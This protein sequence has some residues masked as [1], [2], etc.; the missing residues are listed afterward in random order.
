VINDQQLNWNV[1]GSLIGNEDNHR[2]LIALLDQVAKDDR[3]KKLTEKCD[4]SSSEL[5]KYAQD[6][7]Q[8]RL[9]L[10]KAKANAIFLSEEERMAKKLINAYKSRRDRVSRIIVI[11]IHD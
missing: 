2:F 1:C 6:Y 11:F 4:W 5:K 10:A 8:K 7:Y 3:V 9:E